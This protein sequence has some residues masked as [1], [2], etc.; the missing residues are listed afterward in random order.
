MQRIVIFLLDLLEVDI[1]ALEKRIDACFPLGH[2]SSPVGITTVPL[3]GEARKRP[4]GL[5]RLGGHCPA[6][7]T[8]CGGSVG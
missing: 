6:S 2:D 7:N 1:T 4:V 8:S 3:G 5:Q